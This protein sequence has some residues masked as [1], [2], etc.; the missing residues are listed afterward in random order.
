MG[1][2]RYMVPWYPMIKHSVFI[3]AQSNPKSCIFLCSKYNGF[4]QNLESMLYS[5]TLSC[6]LHLFPLLTPRY[7]NVHRLHGPTSTLPFM[8]SGS[9]LSC[10]RLNSQ[11][12]TFYSKDQNSILSYEIYCRQNPERSPRFHVALFV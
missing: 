6:T 12:S 9:S 1:S 11:L 2:S 3:W 4:F 8:Q 7:Y 5:P 10:V